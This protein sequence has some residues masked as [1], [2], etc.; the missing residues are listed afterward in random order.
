MTNGTFMLLCVAKKLIH[1]YQSQSVSLSVSTGY[2]KTVSAL[3]I[4]SN[5]TENNAEPCRKLIL[6]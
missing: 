6:Y 3:Y 4:S 5:Y 1:C 2:V